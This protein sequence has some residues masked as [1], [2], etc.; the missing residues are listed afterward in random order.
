MPPFAWNT[1]P[2]KVLACCF[3]ALAAAVLAGPMLVYGAEQ[4]PARPNILFCSGGEFDRYLYRRVR[5]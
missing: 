3:A 2:K 4:A 1:S 5:H